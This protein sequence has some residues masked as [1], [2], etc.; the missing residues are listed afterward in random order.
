MSASFVLHRK[1]VVSVSA[2]L[3]RPATNRPSLALRHPDTLPHADIPARLGYVVR[4]GNDMTITHAGVSSDDPRNR[5][6][7]GMIRPV[8]YTPAE[9]QARFVARERDHEG[10][11]GF[12]AYP[13]SAGKPITPVCSATILPTSL[14]SGCSTAPAAR[15]IFSRAMKAPL[16]MVH[17]GAPAVLADLVTCGRLSP[18]APRNI[19][20]LMA[21]YLHLGAVCPQGDRNDRRQVGKPGLRRGMGRYGFRADALGPTQ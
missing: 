12:V 14:T 17:G 18:A 3:C 9:L 19:V 11:P 4:L 2:N 7:M 16:G 5:G 1:A 6:L 21:F 10:H 15:V 20:M 8:E 13:I